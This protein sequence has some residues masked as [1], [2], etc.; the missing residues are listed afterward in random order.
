MN[1]IEAL[2]FKIGK[3][4]ISITEKQEIGLK[5]LIVP[6]TKKQLHKLL[7]KLSYFRGF[8]P[9]YAGK[10]QEIFIM[11]KDKEKFSWNKEFSLIIKRIIDEILNCKLSIVDSEQVE[12]QCDASKTAVGACLYSD[13][14]LFQCFSKLL[15]ESPVIGPT[16]NESSTR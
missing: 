10:I 1:E 14:L 5:N 8:V 7:A 15:P 11:L 9:N 3:E 13:G 6:K 4:V 12:I 2:G 16:L